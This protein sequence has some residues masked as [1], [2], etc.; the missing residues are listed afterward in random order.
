MWKDV[1]KGGKMFG[2]FKK[3]TQEQRCKVGKNYES[4]VFRK[5]GY[6]KKDTKKVRF[7]LG[8]GRTWC[9]E[10]QPNVKKRDNNQ[11]ISSKR[12]KCHRKELR[13]R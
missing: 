4:D 10:F 3:E 11:A 2:K 6:Q 7:C 12:R 5:K 1:A 9:M 13:S 8:T